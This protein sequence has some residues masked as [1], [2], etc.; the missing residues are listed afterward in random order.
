MT[1]NLKVDYKLVKEAVK[2]GR[3]KTQQAAVK[4]AL[5]EY[6][7]RKKQSEVVKLFNKIDYE[8]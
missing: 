5:E 3:H 4:R 2:V 8:K 7:M 6:I 1:T